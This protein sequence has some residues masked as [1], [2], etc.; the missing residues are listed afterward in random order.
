MIDIMILRQSYER[1]KIDKIRQIY[2]KNNPAN[3]I[4]KKSPNLALEKIISINKA[5]IRLE[6]QVK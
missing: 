5:I 1:Q 2:N 4:T 6:R 3:A